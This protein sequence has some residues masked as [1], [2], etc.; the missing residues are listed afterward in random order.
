MSVN[1][2][3]L[4]PFLRLHFVQAETTFFQLVLPCKHLGT[5]WSKVNSLAEKLLL[6]YWHVKL[7]HKKTLK[8]VKAG[9]R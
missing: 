5:K 6:Q 2:N 1:F 7:S 9:L 8:R 3:N 4:L